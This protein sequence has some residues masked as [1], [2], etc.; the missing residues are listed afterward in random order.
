MSSVGQQSLFIGH[1]EYDDRL[2]DLGLTRLERRRVR[3]DLNETYKIINR[4][5]D[6]SQEL[7]YK[8]DQYD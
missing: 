4:E 3:C 1:W 2:K 5:Y 7:F 8:I 6:V